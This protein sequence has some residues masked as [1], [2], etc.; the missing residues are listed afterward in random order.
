MEKLIQPPKNSKKIKKIVGRGTSSGRGRTSGRGHKGYKSRSGSKSLV[1]FEGGQMPLIRLLPKIGFSNAPHK[2]KVFELKTT[3]I[4]K[5]FN[6]SD[7][8]SIQTLKDIKV[9]KKTCKYVKVIFNGE[10]EN[11][12]LI[13]SSIKLTNRSKKSLLAS[14]GK[15]K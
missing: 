11:K 2:K 7:Q 5:Y 15:I 6:D 12:V 14:G 10:I 1:G 4:N 9:I 13:D 8:I 3:I